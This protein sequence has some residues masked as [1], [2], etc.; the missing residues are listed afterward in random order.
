MLCSSSPNRA[1]RICAYPRAPYKAVQAGDGGLDLAYVIQASPTPYQAWSA[2]A[3]PSVSPSPTP[4]PATLSKHNSQHSMEAGFSL[5]K[6]VHILAPAQ[7]TSEKTQTYVSWVF[8][9][10]SEGLTLREEGGWQKCSEG[11][12]WGHKKVRRQ[13]RRANWRRTERGH[14]SPR[15][16]WPKEAR[17]DSHPLFLGQSLFLGRGTVA[18]VGSRVLRGC[19]R[20]WPSYPLRIDG[21]G[22]GFFRHQAEEP[23]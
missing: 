6:L 18:S 16:G 7:P 2:I 10:Q 22:M 19:G 8:L 5:Y 1:P 12:R 11:K 15:Q 14:R 23:G 20:L 9:G 13:R 4:A 17:G 21:G 3:L